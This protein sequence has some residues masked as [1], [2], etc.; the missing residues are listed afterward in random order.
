MLRGQ[1][2]GRKK[3]M[4]ELIQEKNW[5]STESRGVQLKRI[6]KEVKRI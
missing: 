3:F 5:K 1:D 4:A 2:N 6:N